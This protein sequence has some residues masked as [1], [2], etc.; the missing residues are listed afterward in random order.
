[1]LRL[2]RELARQGLRRLGLG[3]TYRLDD[4]A[5]VDLVAALRAYERLAEAAYYGGEQLLPL[6]CVVRILNEAEKSGIPAEM[7]R[8]YAGSG[9]LFG[10]IPASRIA[11]WYLDR[12][13]ARLAEVDDLTTHEIVELVVGFYDAG[14][15]HWGSASERF[16]S[17]E[18][19]A[20]ELGDRRRHDDALANL[21]ELENLRGSFADA[22]AFAIDLVASATARRDRRFEADGLVG[23][24]YATWHLGDAA[25]ATTTLG[26]ARLLLDEQADVTDELRIRALGLAAIAGAG[27]NDTSG[28]V[29]ASEEL[30]RLTDIQPTNFGTFVGCVAPAEVY[31]R[32]LESD[33]GSRQARELASA[34]VK[35]M[36]RFAA[37]FPIG[38]PRAATLE[39]RRRWLIGDRT[40]AIGSWTRAIALAASLT[41]EFELALAHYELG[42]HLDPADDDRVGHLATAIEILERLE[43]GTALESA[44]IALGID[45]PDVHD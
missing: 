39:G 17:V 10:L 8:G 37:V 28:A 12:A 11:Q 22:R 9:A 4:V 25:E 18:R 14:V 27:R 24:A 23:L 38:R 35:R 13:M 33:R 43:A 42:R 36:R 29:D 7:A 40:A 32:L 16:R 19:I 34:A 2:L 21:M 15:G 20:L 31:L 41:M 6:F 45:V 30:M 5:R 44:R 26:R 1:V 3:R